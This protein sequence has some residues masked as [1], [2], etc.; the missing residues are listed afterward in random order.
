MPFLVRAHA[1][2]VRLDAL[3]QPNLE[4]ADLVSPVGRANQVYGATVRARV[5][6]EEGILE[7]REARG[8]HRILARRE[9]ER[10]SRAV[11]VVERHAERVVHE[12]LG[13]RRREGHLDVLALVAVEHRAHRGV[14]S[15]DGRVHRGHR[16]GRETRAHA[17]ERAIEPHVAEHARLGH[18]H[19]VPRAR[20]GTSTSA[21]ACPGRDTYE[22]RILGATRVPTEPEALQHPGAKVFE[23]DVAFAHEGERRVAVSRKVEL[24]DALATSEVVDHV[25]H[26]SSLVLR[27]ARVTR[28]NHAGDVVSRVH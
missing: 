28:A 21:A 8:S 12:R 24:D 6:A 1:R 25:L 22:A 23:E 19:A 14:R 27:A 7:R 2:D 11:P 9:P 26:V 10:A 15:E 16:K 5:L 17:E 13:E 18:D 4:R 20:A 3:E